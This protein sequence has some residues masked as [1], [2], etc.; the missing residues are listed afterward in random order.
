MAEINIDSRLFHER[1]THFA[2]SWKN[3]LRTKDGLF[4]AAAS[5]VVVMGKGEESPD[6]LKNNAMHVSH[7]LH[8]R[9]LGSVKC[10]G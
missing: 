7:Q 8:L 10:F 6:F 2:T 3:D 5:I 9:N 1:L 4:G